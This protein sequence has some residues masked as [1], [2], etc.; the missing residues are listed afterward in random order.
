M[1]GLSKT[2]ASSGALPLVAMLI[3]IVTW[4]LGNILIKQTSVDGLNVAFYRLWFG[5]AVTL[6]LLVLVRHRLTLRE[7]RL[8]APAGAAFGV[9]MVLFF[10]ALK[11]T[12][13]AN[14]TLIGALQPAIVLLIAGPLF[15][16]RV[17]RSEIGWTAVS[18]AGVGILIAGASSSPEWSPLGD[19]MALLAVL[20]FT[21]Y[22]VASKRIRESVSTV[23]YM[24][25]VHL[26]AAVI[27]T[28]V[29]LIHGLEVAALSAAD[30]ARILIIV[31]TSG[32]G[33]HML[34]NWAHPYVK[35]SVSSVIV[36]LTPV[37]ATMGAWVVLDESLTALQ[38]LGGGVTLAAIVAV[39][40]RHRASSV[41]VTE[42]A[43][44][45]EATGA[46]G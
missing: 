15:G 45:R 10:T 4:G 24:A 3:A 6:V 34:V 35:V 29:A 9:N 40:R 18:I 33:A 43:V 30:W 41:D 11:I 17:G 37:V 21:G 39:T 1:R 27:V 19:G 42:T 20:L 25:G 32:V 28:P 8:S 36:L 14:A 5:T 26:G 23:A 46:G 31:F 13:V 16:E 2:E 7:L 12:T 38:L 22:F 44:L